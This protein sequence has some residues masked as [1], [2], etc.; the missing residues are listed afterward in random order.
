M[1]TAE[2]LKRKARHEINSPGDPNHGKLIYMFTEDE[3]DEYR[4]SESGELNEWI[5]EFFKG[6]GMDKLAEAQAKAAIRQKEVE[7]I[8]GI[9]EQYDYLKWRINNQMGLSEQ[10]AREFEYCTYKVEVEGKKN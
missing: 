2:E 5:M 3:L 4:R 9:K 10:Q 6:V 1:K 7:R 8:R